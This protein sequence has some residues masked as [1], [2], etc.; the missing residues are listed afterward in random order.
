[1]Y[2]AEGTAK[3]NE[4]TGIVG[5]STMKPQE[6]TRVGALMQ[7]GEAMSVEIPHWQFRV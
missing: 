6:Q 4:K 3:P 1:M 2:S 5:M 7:G